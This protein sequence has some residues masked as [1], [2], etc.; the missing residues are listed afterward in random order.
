ML[1]TD[2]LIAEL[3]TPCKSDAPCGSAMDYAPEF[4]ALEQLLYIKPEQQYGDVVI[5]E[6]TIDWRAVRTSSEE[7]L[8]QTK[9]LRVAGYWSQAMIALHGL[10]GLSAGLQLT[11]ELLKSYWND[12][13]P[14]LEID[15]EFDPLL[16]SN[17]LLFF[18]DPLGILAYLRR[19]ELFTIKGITVPVSDAEAVFSR[20]AGLSSKF[21]KNQL[22]LMISEAQLDQQSP[23]HSAAVAYQTAK[24]LNDFCK[25]QFGVEISP[26]LSPL[27]SLLSTIN[28]PLTTTDSASV[29]AEE[30][31]HSSSNPAHNLLYNSDK[32]QTAIVSRADAS[33]AIGLICE[34]FES[35]EPASPIPLLLRR[36]QGMIG[37]NFIEIMKELSPDSLPRIEI[38]AG[39]SAID[40]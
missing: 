39:V 29:A 33:R 12:L 5:P 16:R 32:S 13:H 22:N 30:D 34:Y 15:G 20:T 24:S 31:R 37:K 18:S 2:K 23:I 27:L 36:A 7:L 6:S 11:F 38:V 26:D 19:A 4:V 17:T 10:E 40:Q 14:K 35:N 21:D 8:L 3:V 28:F 9:D 25:T 1:L